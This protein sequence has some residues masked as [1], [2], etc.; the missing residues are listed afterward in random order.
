M[1]PPAPGAETPDSP[2]FRTHLETFLSYL[3]FWQDVLEHCRSEEVKQTLLD[4]FQVLFLQ[5]LLFAPPS[6]PLG[7]WMLILWQNRYPSLLES[8]DVDGGSSVA[9]LTYVRVVLETLD[10]P[11]IIHLI[12]SYLMNLPEK[13]EKI[14][15]PSR[16]KRRQ[17]LD[18]LSKAADVVDS[19]TP[20]IYSLA[21]L[22]MTSLSSKSQQTVS[23]TLRLVSTI[24]RKHYPYSMHTLLKTTPVLSRV[25]ARTIGAHNEEMDLLFRMAS[26]LTGQDKNVAQ[27]YEDHIKDC[28]VLLESHPCTTKFLGLKPATTA[29]SNGS[30]DKLAQMHLHTLS[31][32]DPLLRHLVDL[33]SKFFF[34]TVETNLVLTCVIVDLAACS[35]MRPEGWLFYDPAAYEFPGE[36]DSELEGEDGLDSMKDELAEILKDSVFTPEPDLVAE[37]DRRRARDATRARRRPRL[38]KP[39]PVIE[40]LQSLVSQVETYR[41]AIPELDDKLMVRRRA[42]EFTDEISEAVSS[43]QAAQ[44]SPPP[45][46][47]PPPPS[48]PSPPPPRSPLLPPRHPARPATARSSSSGGLDLVSMFENHVADTTQ[49]TIKWMMPG[50]RVLHLPPPPESGEEGSTREGS[51]RSSGTADADVGD[52]HR[53]ML[54]GNAGG[55]FTLSHLLT[56]IMILQVR[57]SHYK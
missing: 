41:K 16:A 22:I 36:S 32:H 4:H 28:Q 3:T 11:D 27:S 50:Q 52:M 56:N 23:A 17:S 43:S 15:S 24:L 53:N 21:D 54:K 34:N 38:R 13:P 30:D 46:P 48:G 42:F 7:R 44:H 45:P 51:V 18:M 25:P 40:A 29:I 47:P 20:A 12:L 37:R 1:P 19:P 8:S 5:Q 10:Y 9:V 35:Y 31:P 39:P 6:L 26:D 33:L 49:R 14:P 55:E 57:I 2:E